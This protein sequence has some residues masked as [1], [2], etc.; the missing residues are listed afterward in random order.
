[1]RM[2]VKSHHEHVERYSL[3]YEDKETPGAGYSFP[4]DKDGNIQHADMHPAGEEN[5]RRCRAGEEDVC[6][7]LVRDESYTFFV[8]ARARCECGTCLDLDSFTN[9]C[10]GCG[11]DYNMSGQLLA[12]REQWS[13]Y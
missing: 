10:E 9:T 7:P 6:A 1:M 11:R 5:L 4:C 13:R 8:C 12:P 3:F 2:V